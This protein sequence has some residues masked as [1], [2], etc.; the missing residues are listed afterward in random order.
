[1]NSYQWTGRKFADTKSYAE[2]TKEAAAHV[3]VPVAD[4]WTAIWEAAGRDERACERFLYDGL[5]LNAAGYE[6]RTKSTRTR[7]GD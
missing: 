7:V 2:A 3:G 1:M 5:H 6:V 4:V